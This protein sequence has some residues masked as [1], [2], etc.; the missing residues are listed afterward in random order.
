MSLITRC[1]ACGTMFKVVTDQLKVS[2][3]WVRCG[4]CANVFDASAHLLPRDMASLDLPLPTPVADTEPMP[5][6]ASMP[7]SPPPQVA[8]A[9][10]PQEW[11]PARSFADRVPL[12]PSSA[13][14]AEAQDSAADFD[15]GRWKRA[16]QER[17][18]DPLELPDSV[19]PQ[20]SSARRSAVM[21]PAVEDDSSFAYSDVDSDMPDSRV[22]HDVS[23]VR[24]AKRK[25]FWRRPL[26]RWALALSSLVLLAVLVLQWA[27]QQRDTLA[28]LEPRLVPGL[29]AICGQLHCDIRAPRHI[30]SV[31]I[32]SSTFNRIGP[33]AYRLSFTLK[34]TGV[35]PLEIPSLE[36]T[37]T[38][39]QDQAVVRRILA[40]AQFGAKSPTLAVRAEL[41][42][43]VI[44]KISADA[45]LSPAS[46]PSS[47]P[48]APLR[49]AG[50]RVLVFYP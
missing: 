16:Q 42:A 19:L 22:E 18:H 45:G 1:P 17:Q 29:Q 35:T 20:E 26:T 28:A 33:D 7:P 12:R 49:V 40:P 31:V 3:G 48:A 25:A 15:P 24:E 50:Y 4:H 44:M 14:F 13:G 34:N 5:L 2:Q 10:D 8:A 23:F 38:D 30:E 32:D 43:M 47:A 46:S 36:V 11:A 6:P 41:P 39:T 21:R 27:V 9:P 37:L